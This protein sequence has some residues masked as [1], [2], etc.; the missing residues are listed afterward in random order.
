MTKRDDHARELSPIAIG[1]A[2]G[3]S[4]FAWLVVD[5]LRRLL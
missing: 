4:A 3:G 1:L 5:V 2:L